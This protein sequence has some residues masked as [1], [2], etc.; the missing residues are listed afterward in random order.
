MVFTVLCRHKCS[1][2]CMESQTDS[3][4]GMAEYCGGVF[5]TY[6]K[7]HIVVGYL[8]K[9]TVWSRSS[10]RVETSGRV[11]LELGMGVA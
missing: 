2:S 9:F 11:Y 5:L 6:F 10:A 7:E 1:C 8:S 3:S 4:L